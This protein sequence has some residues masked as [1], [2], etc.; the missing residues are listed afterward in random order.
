MAQIGKEI[1][2]SSCHSCRS[3]FVQ[4]LMLTKL[5][6]LL[7]IYFILLKLIE[8]L[9]LNCAIFVSVGKQFS[10]KETVTMSLLCHVI[11]DIY[12]V[13]GSAGGGC[14]FSIFPPPSIPNAQ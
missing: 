14:G 12:K 11:S 1:L 8:S 6:S 3:A 2:V 4:H 9:G 5:F 7:I 10:E 13:L